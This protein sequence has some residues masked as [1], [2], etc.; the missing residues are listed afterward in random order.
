[1]NVFIAI[2]TPNN[3]AQCPAL[4]VIPSNVKEPRKPELKALRY[5][6]DDVGANEVTTMI[7]A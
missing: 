5:N 4:K 3:S 7:A 1:M 6:G 2:E